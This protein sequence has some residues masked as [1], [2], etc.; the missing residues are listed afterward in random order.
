MRAV[1]SA[2]I[3]VGRGLTDT[4]GLTDNIG[5]FLDPQGKRNYLIPAGLIAGGLGG[6]V[7]APKKH[8]KLIALSGLIGGYFVGAYFYKEAPGGA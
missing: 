2:T 7:L 3:V 1:N 6:Y 4:S 8:K 5:K